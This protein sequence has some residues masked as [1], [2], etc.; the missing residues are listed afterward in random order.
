MAT[1]RTP[2]EAQWTPDAATFLSDEQHLQTSSASL[3][4]AEALEKPQDGPKRAQRIW[5]SFVQQAKEIVDENAGMLLVAASEVFYTAMS[6]A[7]KELGSIDPPMS[8]MQLIWIYMIVTWLCSIFY[9]YI[10][11]IP[12]PLLGPQGVRLLLAFRGLCGFIAFFGIY[13]SVLYLT[14][15]DATVLQFL[16]PILTTFTGFIFLGERFSWRQLAAGFCSLIGVILIARPHFLFGSVSQTPPANSNLVGANA[17]PGDVSPLSRVT[18]A[19]R[20]GAVGIALLGALGS[21]GV[22]TTIRAIG[23]RAHSLHNINSVSQQCVIMSTIGQVLCHAQMLV[24]QT[25]IVIPT[26][27]IWIALLLVLGFSSFFAQVL[28]TMGLRRHSV[29]RTTMAVYI[30]IV[31]AII[32]DEIFFHDAPSP[33]SICGTLII[34]LSAVYVALNKEDAVKVKA[35]SPDDLAL[36]EGLLAHKDVDTEESL[37]TREDV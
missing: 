15:A 31:Y 16:A 24:T 22:Y 10:A 12:D 32:F 1:T 26:S 36:Q 9:M 23:T 27:P 20:L 33:L 17:N 14:L 34:V 13:Y 21:T 37:K 28:M 25:K 8:T 7:V 2:F 6:L 29:G 4:E 35:E 30:E 3:E 11:K 18:A 5:A 19:Q